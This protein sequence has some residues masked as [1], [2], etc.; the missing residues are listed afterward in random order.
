MDLNLGEDLIGT[1][2]LGATPKLNRNSTQA[3][4]CFADRKPLSG[5]HTTGTSPPPP[6]QASI[7]GGAMLGLWAIVSAWPAWSL[8]A[9]GALS[10]GLA[11]VVVCLGVSPAQNFEIYSN[12]LIPITLSPYM[13]WPCKSPFVF[14]K[15]L[16]VVR[17]NKPLID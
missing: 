13:R 15:S 11:V 1:S 2:R 17:R 5:L 8:R 10:L 14:G 3:Y 12:V 6:I 16:E 9:L 7:L 4:I